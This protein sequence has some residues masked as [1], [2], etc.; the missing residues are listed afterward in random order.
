MSTD[1]KAPGSHFPDELPGDGLNETEIN[2]LIFEG[3]APLEVPPDQR[4]S[5]RQRLLARVAESRRRH[6]GLVTVRAAD[7]TWRDIKAG[8]RAK[9][10]REGPAG[11]SVLIE[12]APG[13]A[14]PVHR[15]SHL[16]E[17][18]VLQGGLQLDDLELGPG[19]YHVS[20]AGSR[21]GRIS[22][23]QGGLAY[24][25]GTSLGHP[26]DALG[27]LI[28]GLLPGDGPA[29]HTIRAGDGAWETIADGAEQKRLWRDGDFISRFIRLAPGSRLPA[30]AHEGEEECI[31]LAG[32]AFF[33]DIL[34]RAGEFHLAPD[35]SVHL[36]T[37]SET[38]GL[39]FLRN[40]KYRPV[41]DA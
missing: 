2:R 5:L 24:L 16:E 20:P 39:A 6:A 27:E 21:H 1:P 18:I 10:L 26:I 22:S 3:L 13:A 4:G 25:R 11:A 35:G 14:L 40:R 31:M 38:G 15:H 12:L 34:V 33:G 41:P 28:G 7:G 30:H 19:D 29:A 8:V 37:L 23:R 36:E 32:E 9:T 17:G